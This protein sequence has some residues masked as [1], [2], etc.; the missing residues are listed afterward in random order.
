MTNVNSTLVVNDDNLTF[1]YGGSNS[2]NVTY[3]GASGVNATVTGHPEANVTITG[4]V[5]TVS[6]LAAGNYTLNI[7][8]L[9]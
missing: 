7:T 9:R 5:I 8:T 2:T 3:E 6:G 1:A 4:D